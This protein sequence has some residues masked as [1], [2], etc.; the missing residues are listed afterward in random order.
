[1]GEERPAQQCSW[2][3]TNGE[4]KEE[5][6]L[7]FPELTKLLSCHTNSSFHQVVYMWITST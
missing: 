6:F 7:L 4:F 1:M 2:E 3:G 5:I